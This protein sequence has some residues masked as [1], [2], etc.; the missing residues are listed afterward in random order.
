MLSI[1]SHVSQ[2]TFSFTRRTYNNNRDSDRQAA[3]L[4]LL[5]YAQDL[6]MLF[7]IL[8]QFYPVSYHSGGLSLN[9]SAVLSRKMDFVLETSKFI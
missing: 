5:E 8:D 6:S 3:F 2:T 9:N 4:C 1:K 7:V